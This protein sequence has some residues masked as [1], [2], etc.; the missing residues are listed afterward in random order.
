MFMSVR[1]IRGAI[2]VEADR[3]DQ[4]LAATRELL[5]TILEANPGLE[6]ADVASVLF[7]VTEDI[8]SVH[9]ALAARRMGWDL[10]PM[11]CAREIPVPCSLPR[12]IR[13][14]LLWNTDV[15]QNAIHHVYLRQAVS[16]RPDL[17]QA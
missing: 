10:V 13:V 16:L 6:T 8:I 1:G 17:A 5:E 3:P 12:C 9:P 4:V 2:T 7:T 15:P 11:I 14:L